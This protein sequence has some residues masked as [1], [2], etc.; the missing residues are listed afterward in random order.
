MAVDYHSELQELV[1]LIN[2]FQIQIWW[3]PIIFPNHYF[4]QFERTE[5]VLELD[6]TVF[7]GIASPTNLS[8]K[9]I[10]DFD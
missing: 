3:S 4:I 8:I 1:I 7:T 10:E 2:D 5:Y 6:A 9:K